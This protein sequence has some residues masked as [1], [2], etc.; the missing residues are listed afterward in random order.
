MSQRWICAN[1]HAGSDTDTLPLVCPLC[2]SVALAADGQLAM[3]GFPSGSLS[4]VTLDRPPS[5]QAPVPSPAEKRPINPI[6]A[7]R[8]TERIDIPHSLPPQPPD[9]TLQ[10]PSGLVMPPAA[11]VAPADADAPDQTLQ[12]PSGLLV[13]PAAPS[14]RT[15][16]ITQSPDGPLTSPIDGPITQPVP[17]RP[18]ETLVRPSNAPSGRS[19][20]GTGLTAGAPTGSF[21]LTIPSG[22]ATP[23]S[24][25][26]GFSAMGPSAL[27][28]SP[29]ASDYEILG[30]L[31]RG[32]MGV[33]YKARQ[34]GL[35]RV[36]AL[37][38]ILAGS[39]ASAEELLRFKIEAESVAELQHPN[40][41]QVYDFGQRDGRPFFSLEYLDGGSLQQK[42]D[43][44]PRDPRWCAQLI[45]TLARAMDFAHRRGIVHRDLKPANILLTADGVPKITDFG[46][47]KR[48][49][50]DSGQTG[51]EAI[52]GTPTYMAPEQA[53][54]NKF[55]IG[56][57]ADVYALGAI[58][59][60]VLTGR[61]PFKGA[62]ALDTIQLVQ[63]AEPVPPSR[64]QAKLPRDLETICLKCL[65]KDP[66]RRYPTAAALADDLLAF[67]ERRPIQ[68]RPVGTLE[69]AWKWAARRPAVAGLIASVFL[70]PL[71]LAAVIGAYS[72]HVRSLN[73]QLNDSKIEVDNK[74]QQLEVTNDKLT[75]TNTQLQESEQSLKTAYGKLEVEH[76]NTLRAEK[77]AVRAEKEAERNFLV[78]QRATDELLRTAR[79]GLRNRPGME[80]VRRQLLA[81]GKK[82]AVPFTATSSRTPAARLRA[83]GAHR[84][85]GELEEALG[86]HKTAVADYES[87]LK[88]YRQ[89]MASGPRPSWLEDYEREEL[90]VAMKRFGAQ[91]FLDPVRAEAE[92]NQLLAR[93]E[94]PIP[95]GA[96]ADLYRR[97][98]AALLANRALHAQLRGA[99]TA[100]DTDYRA[101]ASLL[102]P[103]QER[104]GGQMELARL[105]INQAALWLVMDGSQPGGRKELLQ[106][107][108]DACGKALRTLDALRQV[109]PNNVEVATETARAYTNLGL[110]LL[111]QGNARA[112]AKMQDDAITFFTTLAQKSPR[113]VD[114]RQLLAASLGN[115]GQTLIRAAKPEAA[116][117]LLRQ[118]RKLLEELVAGFDDVTDYRR[119]LVRVCD[120]QGLAW[121]KGKQPAQALEPLERAYALCRLSLRREPG[122]PVLVEDLVMV[123]RNLV[124]C[125]DQLARHAA[126]RK[127]WNVA[128]R[129]I[130]RLVELR[131]EHERDLPALEPGVSLG[132]R[133]WRI[134][135]RIGVRVELIGTLRALASVQEERRDHA[136]AA[137][138]VRELA[139]LI[140]PAWPG[141]VDSAA[142]LARC[143]RLAQTDRGLVS[144][145]ARQA[146]EYA[147]EAFDLLQRL[148]KH[149]SLGK[150]LRDEDFDVLRSVPGME[151][152][153][154]AFQEQVERK[155]I[156]IAPP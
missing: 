83:A 98:H 154:R 137:R 142:L 24:Q 110:V 56:P 141:Y 85:L 128:E 19:T 53:Q 148:A 35:N 13:P 108:R 133:L 112:A 44:T 152:E 29:P 93:F 8:P 131:R 5:G 89:L 10:R 114:F 97:Y 42:L 91:E 84:Q 48:F 55:K 46:L 65:E 38:M 43:G 71:V 51:T 74:N 118:A 101:A 3:A 31:G 105:Q 59:Y 22:S 30:L 27:G 135:E 127:E 58:L 106:Q 6:I 147:K 62:T 94:K 23:F 12:R 149:Q 121:L 26:S 102:E 140:S 104:S 41:V 86:D 151:K 66:S 143:V 134:A 107:A 7:T 73:V 50:E 67:L 111:N 113:I 47:A 99:Y 15:T 25:T 57:P 100:A 60:D 136:G 116:L 17:P 156:P 115:R 77:E 40:I 1:G 150:R 79:E 9:Q 11:P 117:P 132:A 76:S 70:G 4:D 145:C 92:L 126:D 90:G 32:G 49:Q 75:T 124:A 54:G 20:P 129:S 34:I 33:V 63:T 69:R 120:S 81:A 109:H 119:D 45:E 64:W 61:P 78:A 72:L 88:L 144:T 28:A 146:A 16:P 138:S 36:V 130:V 82:M 52:L 18:D 123:R 139:P 153:F 2:G 103:E 87:S 37:K 122:R 21:P 155:Q 95:A 80:D 96:N 39:H 125:L 14:A 68:A